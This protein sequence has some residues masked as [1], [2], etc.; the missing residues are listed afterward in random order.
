MCRERKEGVEWS[1][2]PSPSH[3]SSIQV[4]GAHLLALA[5]TSS[6]LSAISGPLGV[7]GPLGFLRSLRNLGGPPLQY[8][9]SAS[10][11]PPDR[12]SHRKWRESKQQL[13]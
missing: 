13:I 10:K 12:M 9:E 2:S 3:P 4:L 5:C 8:R 6:S 11:R 1:G 7:D